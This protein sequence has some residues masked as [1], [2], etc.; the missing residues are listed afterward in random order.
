M[1]LCEGSDHVGKSLS[2]KRSK[3]KGT[4]MTWSMG[5]SSHCKRLTANGQ[6]GIRTC[7]LVRLMVGVAND[8]TSE[9]PS[10]NSTD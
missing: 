3:P 4:D 1:S 9:L 2:V 6:L 7:T 8:N 5:F 10:D